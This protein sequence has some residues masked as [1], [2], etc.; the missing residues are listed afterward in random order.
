MYSKQLYKFFQ[1]DGDIHTTQTE[2]ITSNA[3]YQL[4]HDQPFT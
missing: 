4:H 1:G 2:T 3:L